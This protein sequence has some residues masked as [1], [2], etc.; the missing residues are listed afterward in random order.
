MLIPIH[1][2]ENGSPCGCDRP[3]VAC[4]EMILEF[5][6]LTLGFPQYFSKRFTALPAFLPPPLPS[7]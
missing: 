3:K 4:V 5:T 1:R 2:R 6:S 7:P